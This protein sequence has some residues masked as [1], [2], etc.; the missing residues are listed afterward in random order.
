[1]F[2][3]DE[4]I[5]G[6]GI[7]S[8]DGVEYR[9]F[10][11]FDFD[12]DGK[13]E[14]RFHLSEP[15]QELP[16]ELPWGLRGMPDESF[17]FVATVEEWRV[18]RVRHFRLLNARIQFDT[19]MGGVFVFSFYEY[20]N[21]IDGAIPN[22][23]DACS[24]RF[25]GMESLI[26]G[27]NWSFQPLEDRRWEV[28]LLDPEE[29]RVECERFTLEVRRGLRSAVSL[30]GFRFRPL[31]SVALRFNERE[32]LMECRGM[33][34]AVVVFASILRG[35]A[36]R[37]NRLT[38]E[39][40]TRVVFR[41]SP[42]WRLLG[43]DTPPIEEVR[44]SFDFYNYGFATSLPETDISS[45]NR[46]VF[47]DAVERFRTF[48]RM[49]NRNPGAFRNL[50]GL[51]HQRGTL[52]E[53]RVVDLCSVA[54]GLCI[55]KFG[56]KFVDKRTMKEILYYVWK[57]VDGYFDCKRIFCGRIFREGFNFNVD[58]KFNCEEFEKLME[59]FLER[60]VRDRRVPRAHSSADPFHTG[61]DGYWEDEFLLLM[62][63]AFVM[64]HCNFPPDLALKA[65][66]GES[67]GTSFIHHYLKSPDIPEIQEQPRDAPDATP[68]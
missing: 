25:E 19:G 68:N 29:K 4:K 33:A 36:S 16:W 55:A 53:D 58:K 38:L 56:K 6:Y 49:Y 50:S 17:D 28:Q 44:R 48:Y 11:V 62:L 20:I 67:S 41:N 32:S 60:I 24:V 54:E 18:G 12:E 46:G 3:K 52:L 59:K 37:I 27:K 5:E 7:I 35:E 23:F 10:A 15:S 66:R 63:R 43:W 51:P 22:E 40:R 65:L 14:L 45:L 31:V 13:G 61:K 26:G 21:S 34:Y 57:D 8:K 64:K 39:A 42:N 1:M 2:S 9:G 47:F 30:D